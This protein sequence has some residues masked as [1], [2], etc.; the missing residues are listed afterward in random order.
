[1]DFVDSVSSVDWENVPIV[2]IGTG[3]GAK[4]YT[5]IKRVKLLGWVKNTNQTQVVVQTEGE[6]FEWRARLP[7]S[8]S[9][10]MRNRMKN[11]VCRVMSSESRLFDVEVSL[12]TEQQRRVQG[13]LKVESLQQA[14]TVL[15][16]MSLP[17]E[18]GDRDME[19]LKV[20]VREALLEGY[21]M[22]SLKKQSSTGPA[23]GSIVLDEN[24]SLHLRSRE[25]EVGLCDYD[26]YPYAIQRRAFQELLHDLWQS[27]ESNG[28]GQAR[29][30][31]AQSFDL[32]VIGGLQCVCDRICFESVDRAIQET[33]PILC[34][35][36]FAIGDDR[37]HSF[38]ETQMELCVQR[39][40]TQRG[41]SAA[42]IRSF[43]HLHSYGWPFLAAD[44][45]DLRPLSAAEQRSRLPA[46]RTWL[47]KAIPS[48]FDRFNLLILECQTYSSQAFMELVGTLCDYITDRKSTA[49]T[50][51]CANMYMGCSAEDVRVATGPFPGHPF[52]SLEMKRSHIW[53]N[54]QLL[55]PQDYI[56]LGNDLQFNHHWDHFMTSGVKTASLST[57]LDVMVH[58][59]YHPFDLLSK[60]GKFKS[61]VSM[62]KLP[63]A[64]RTKIAQKHDLLKSPV[65]YDLQKSLFPPT[66]DTSDQPDAAVAWALFAY[67]YHDSES[68]LCLHIGPQLSVAQAYTAARMIRVQSK[69]GAELGADTFSKSNKLSYEPLTVIHPK[70]LKTIEYSAKGYNAHVKPLYSQIK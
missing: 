62:S 65:I 63:S 18:R 32:Q 46:F 25:A 68:S 57:L 30:L 14:V 59:S 2:D 36:P 41:P 15:R 48:Q 45:G 1:M 44:G 23:K 28:T 27:I 39:C 35:H 52:M 3:K 54:A 66:D 53:M 64:L 21:D 37:L 34:I 49:P 56:G 10:Q 16:S 38:L 19:E 67:I 55:M 31:K 11:L 70:R 20:L 50:F 29:M 43:G 13:G 51:G 9:L 6:S 26:V 40:L 47:E 42:K 17:T 22:V 7:N 60:A 58:T 24:L 8:E 5:K 61:A 4:R 33:G 12:T 69:R